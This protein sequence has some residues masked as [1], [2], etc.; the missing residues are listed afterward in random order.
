[1]KYEIEERLAQAVL[2][3]LSTRPYR[4]VFSLVSGLTSL[5]KIEDGESVTD[6]RETVDAD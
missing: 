5:K 1:M 3:Y 4:E 2:D 6:D